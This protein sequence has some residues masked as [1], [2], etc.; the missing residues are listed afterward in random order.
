MLSTKEP[1]SYCVGKGH[2]RARNKRL[3][4]LFALVRPDSLVDHPDVLDEVGLLV[5]AVLAVVADKRT[6][7]EVNRAQ[8][9]VKVAFRFVL[10]HKMT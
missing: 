5:E 4:N 2:T 8:V 7:V 10:K 6:L 3:S 9:A 1:T